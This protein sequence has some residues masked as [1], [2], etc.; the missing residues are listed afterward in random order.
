MAKPNAG[1]EALT[2]NRKRTLEREIDARS[3]GGT[4]SRRKPETPPANRSSTAESA[5]K[6]ERRVQGVRTFGAPTS[7]ETQRL[8]NAQSTDSNN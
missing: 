5:R 4:R 3:G 1:A 6:T 8:R 7:S 2:G